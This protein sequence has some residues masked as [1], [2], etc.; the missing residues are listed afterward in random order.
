M[1]KNIPSAMSD[2]TDQWL[3]EKISAHP[4]FANTPIKSIQRETVGEGIGQVGEFNQVLQKPRPA[5][6]PNYF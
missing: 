4:D 5:R 2:V 1:S 6:A 3:I